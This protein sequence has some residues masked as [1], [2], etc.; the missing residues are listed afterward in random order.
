MKTKNA[1]TMIELVFVIIVLGILSVV[2]LPRFIGV[3]DESKRSLCDAEIGTMNR[4]VG[5]NFWSA[6]LSAG[7]DGNIS[8]Y[9]TVENMNKNFPDY[10]ATE[11]G[12]LIGLR[13]GADAAGDGVYG[14]PRLLNDGNVSHAPKW[15]WIKK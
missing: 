15:E 3:A 6:S 7:N 2:A 14:S 5:L 8:S 10:N 13:A 12:S 9:V 4:T 1:F 11:C